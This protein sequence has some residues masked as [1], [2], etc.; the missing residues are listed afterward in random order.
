MK[1]PL[2]LK[3]SLRLIVENVRS[4]DSL[5]QTISQLPLEE[6]VEFFDYAADSRSWIEEEGKSFMVEMLDFFT[7]MALKH[8]LNPSQLTIVATAMRRN[9]AA[10]S[11][12][13]PEDVT[14]VVQEERF[15]PNSLLFRVVG[16]PYFAQLIDDYVATRRQHEIRLPGVSKKSFNYIKEFIYT[17]E[18]KD[19]WKEEPKVILAIQKRGNQWRLKE[20]SDFAFRA[21][22]NYLNKDVLFKRLVAAFLAR[23]V[24]LTEELLTLLE[25]ENLGFSLELIQ[26]SGF[27]LYVRYWYEECEALLEPLF[28]SIFSIDLAD[29]TIEE[30]ALKRLLKRCR[31]LE[32]IDLTS[33]RGCENPVELILALPPLLKRVDLT[34]LTWVNNE[35]LEAIVEHLHN[36]RTLNL[37]GCDHYQPTLLSELSK[38]KELDELILSNNQSLTLQVLKIICPLLKTIKALDVTNCQGINDLGIQLISVHMHELEELHLAKIRNISEQ[39]L[40]PLAYNKTLRL[41]DLRQMAQI[42]SNYREKNQRRFFRTEILI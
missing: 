21:Y 31:R 16:E 3:D 7:L 33:I 34:D 38:M 28:D 23:N 36:L 20:V 25:Q 24:H 14:F 30:F 1:A 6:R 10:L 40:L 13:I 41:L 2:G 35:T 26:E 5:Y 12:M 8:Q 37:S 11:N 19:L 27:K 18:M 15:K 22:K 29:E 4:T 9:C 32:E 17:G 42:P 39:G